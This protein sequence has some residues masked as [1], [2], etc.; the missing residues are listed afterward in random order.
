MQTASL[1]QLF[2]LMW[3]GERADEFGLDSA[4]RIGLMGGNRLLVYRPEGHLI[5][6]SSATGA[7]PALTAEECCLKANLERAFKR[8]NAGALFML[9]RTGRP[10]GAALGEEMED[11]LDE[12]QHDW[13][14]MPAYRPA[15]EGL[16]LADLCQLGCRLGGRPYS[17]M[18]VRIVRGR[19]ITLFMNGPAAVEAHL[20]VGG[21]LRV[22]RRAGVPLTP[23]PADGH[24]RRLHARFMR[25]AAGWLSAF[26]SGEEDRL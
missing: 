7:L 2:R 12:L 20:G 15:G 22:R 9:A 23:P 19:G 11:R 6:L 4:G 10:W 13:A 1:F 21:S 3:H 17:L 18:G 25:E 24:T 14:A 5:G 8:A 26:E 16:P